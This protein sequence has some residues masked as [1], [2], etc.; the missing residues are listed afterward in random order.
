M[1]RQRDFPREIRVRDA[2]YQV[3]FRR[4]LNYEGEPCYGLCHYDDKLI[5]ICQG[6]SPSFRAEIFW[7]EVFHA[8]AHE[9]GF[10]LAHPT[11]YKLQA[12]WAK[13]SRDNGISRVKMTA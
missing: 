10:R 12:A 9:W 11:I 1:N 13:F 3:R 4:H 5:E 7:H 8:F 2:V 6:M